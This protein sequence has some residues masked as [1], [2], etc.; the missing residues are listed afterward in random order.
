[1]GQRGG[2][3]NFTNRAKM[4]RGATALSLDDKGRLA[5]PSKYRQP[6]QALCSGQL[7]V[8]IDPDRCLPI[9]PLT[10]W[11]KVEQELDDMPD[12]KR[13]KCLKRLL[14]GPAEECEMDGQGRILLSM[15]LREFAGL[16]KKVVLIGQGNKFELWQEERW[17]QLRNQW[18]SEES[19]NDTDLMA[20]LESLSAKN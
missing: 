19:E 4:F 15:A 17:Y 13:A 18:L 14:I 2:D 6:L 16:L 1:V 10:M 8:T 9:Y 12:A 20:T 7:I 11:E 3:W 5:L